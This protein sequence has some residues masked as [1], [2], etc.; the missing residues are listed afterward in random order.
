MRY[1][2][3]IFCYLVLVPLGKLSLTQVTRSYRDR[4]LDWETNLG[5]ELLPENIW[6]VQ[7]LFLDRINKDLEQ[8]MNI[9]NCHA[10]STE[11]Y[12]S[13]NALQL[14]DQNDR[15]SLERMIDEG[16]VNDVIASLEVE[17]E[18][19]KVADNISP[20]VTAVE[21]TEFESRVSVVKLDEKNDQIYDK[22]VL[23]YSVIREIKIRRII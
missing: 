18:G 13:L 23:A 19:K 12:C 8:F 6:I 5:L 4:F 17:Y 7:Y 11:K 16:R 1:R 2:L 14:M 20:F 9:W 21:F 15:Y 10:M 3:I 22:L